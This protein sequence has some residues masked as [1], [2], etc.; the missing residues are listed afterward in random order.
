MPADR[1]SQLKRA[2]ARTRALLAAVETSL[3]DVDDVDD[4]IGEH[5]RAADAAVTRWTE[6]E[7]TRL[8]LSGGDPD[9]ESRYRWHLRQRH[10]ARITAA[11]ADHARARRKEG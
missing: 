5:A 6:K 8:D 2:A 3:R 11:M 7:R 10:R 1:S 9:A 4:Q